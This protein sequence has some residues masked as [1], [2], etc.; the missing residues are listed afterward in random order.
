MTARDIIRRALRIAQVIGE[1]EDPT[2][3]DAETDALSTLNSLLA[4][5]GAERLLV[6]ALVTDTLTLTTSKDEYTFGTGGDINSARPHRIEHAFIRDSGS[7]DF[8]VSII[9]AEDYNDITLKT[10][11]GRPTH[12]Y[13]IAE[14]P[15][16]RIKLYYVPDAAET[17]H[18]DSWKPLLSISAAGDTINLPREYQLALEYNLAPAIAA[19]VAQ[20][21]SRFVYD[22]AKRTKNIIKALNAVPVMKRR[23]DPAFFNYGT[24]GRNI[25]NDGDT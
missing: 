6:P 11:T 7:N 24:Y 20:Q 16:A 1:G 19:E 9:H 10:T 8:P 18:M 5:W 21:L 4:S 2:G 25:Y 17:L 12:L 14:F 22:E 3:E 13:F 23:C 15:L